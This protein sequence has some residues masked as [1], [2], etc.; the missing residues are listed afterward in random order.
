MW[1]LN[2]RQQKIMAKT[3]EMQPQIKAIQTKY[4]DKKVFDINKI[5]IYILILIKIH[6]KVLTDYA[7]YL[8]IFSF[9]HN[10][11]YLEQPSQ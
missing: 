10:N 1:P 6:I 8:V 5:I 7:S 9:F 11:L 2:L 3:Q 4:K